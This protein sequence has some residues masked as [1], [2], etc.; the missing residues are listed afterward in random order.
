[1][2]TDNE[3]AEIIED[4]LV[5]S[6][7]GLDQVDQDLVELERDPSNLDLITRIFRVVHTIKGTCGFLGFNQLEAI[8]HVGE[9]LLVRLRD[10]KQTLTTEITEALLNLFDSVKEI[11]DAIESTGK[12]SEKDFTPITDL[13][14]KLLENENGDDQPRQCPTCGATISEEDNAVEKIQSGGIS[15][16]SDQIETSGVP[17]IAQAGE[18]LKTLV[19]NT[20]E[21]NNS[22]T[23]TLKSSE[24]V[25]PQKQSIA[26]SSIRVG[27]DLLDHL[28]NLV[29]ELV[30]S[31]NQIVRYTEGNE[32]TR[33]AL[34]GQGLNGI[35][36]DLQEGVMKTRMQAI[37]TIWNKFPRVVRDLSAECEKKVRLEMEGA[38]TE[39]DKTIVEAIKDPLTHIIRNS[40]D[41]G[42]E[43]SEQREASG[44]PAEGLLR[45]R[46]FHESGQV[47]IEIIDD[48]AGVNPEKVKQK[49]LEKGLVTEE[50]ANRMNQREMQYL[51]FMPGFSTAEKVSNV[52]GRGVG[53]DVVKTNIKKIGGSVDIISKVGKGTTLRVKIP[54]TLAIIPALSVTSAGERFA[55]PQL[56][57]L[58]LLRLEQ[59][60]LGTG[61]E[62]V[63]GTPLYRLRGDLLP[64]VYLN[65]VLAIESVVSTDEDERVEDDVVNIVV[66]QAEE[67]KFC[68][69]VDEINDSQ[70]IVVKPLG[71]LMKD[72]SVFAGATIMGDG[73]VALILDVMGLARS[74]RVKSESRIIAGSNA[75]ADSRISDSSNLESTLLFEIGDNTQAAIPLSQVAR[76]EKIDQSKIEQAGAN[77]VTQYR[78]QILP[79][80]PISDFLQDANNESISSRWEPRNENIA[81][82]AVVYSC[83]GENYGLVVQRIIDIVE[84]ELKVKGR[85]TRSH[86]LGTAVIR[87]KVHEVIDIESIIHAEFGNLGRETL[88]SEFPIATEPNRQPE[89]VVSA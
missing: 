39:L 49:A 66:L 13:L 60:N 28:M 58:E 75:T 71:N 68:L 26:D 45:L 81:I 70:D 14:T 89:E 40:V 33:I 17:E 69:I 32:D 50:Q 55:I 54:L 74:A 83:G 8:T 20:K 88:K 87:N 73:R 18:E 23:K 38:D 35:T 31:R 77:Y 36:S 44:K 65:R 10:G 6:H 42:I 78:G 56:N 27:V 57:L 5:E 15:E 34:A 24:R 41:H 64:V 59:E 3:F 37:G 22:E 25:T 47:N 52:S 82:S 76:L 2:S 21:E 80:L 7:E 16:E 4:F 12:E 1:M 48:G 63:H 62:T 53:M 86:I 46:A 79:L 61:I 67:Q 29:G 9:N 30:L 51:L 11:L 84:E 19:S 85:A 72:L 43:P